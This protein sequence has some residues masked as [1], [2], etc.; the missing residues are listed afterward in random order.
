LEDVEVEFERLLANALT[1]ADP[2]AAL[3]SAAADAPEDVRRILADIDEDG[4]RLSALIIARLRFERLIQC[5]KPAL[6]QFERD[7]RAFAA[8][9]KR[10]HTGVAPVQ[11]SPWDEARAF[12]A[13]L[14]GEP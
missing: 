2:V 9:F 14:A 1:G 13:W 4:V 6:E 7:P 12:E 8:R 10:Y 11:A 5:S 3:R